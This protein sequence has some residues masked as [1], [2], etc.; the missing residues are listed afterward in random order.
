MT[1]SAKR[2]LPILS[3][4]IVAATIIILVGAVWVYL[5]FGT[6]LAGFARTFRAF[7]LG[8]LEEIHPV[9]YFI[10]FALTPALGVPISL[11]YLT[12]ATV[13]G[14]TVDGILW[15]VLL[16]WL[17]LAVNIAFG[18]WLASSFMNPVI[19][20]ILNARGQKIPKALPENEGKVI[21]I[22]RLSP[23]PFAFQNWT[24]G[25]A[26]FQF[27]RYMAYS[28]PIQAALGTGVILVGESFFRGGTGIAI[29]GLFLIC[30]FLLLARMGRKQLGALQEDSNTTQT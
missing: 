30:L 6:D 11:F 24:L 8:F 20:R 4:A 29:F 5:T 26:R 25:V 15:S 2:R 22:C 12:A 18:Y 27:V 7:A 3:L 10:A 28:W 17:A 16:A 21:V 23:L 19:T 9:I 14:S 13:F 1:G